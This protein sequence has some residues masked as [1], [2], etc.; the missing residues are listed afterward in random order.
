MPGPQ[1]KAVILNTV[2]SLMN[3]QGVRN[4]HSSNKYLLSTNSVP[5]TAPDSGS[6]E[7]APNPASGISILLKLTCQTNALEG[8]Q[9]SSNNEW[10]STSLFL[11]K[12]YPHARHGGARL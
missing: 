2:A 6:N 10:M 3:T 11:K 5:D 1:N 9:I 4:F 8:F 12:S 7:I